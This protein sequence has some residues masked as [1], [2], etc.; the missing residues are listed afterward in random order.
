MI[1]AKQHIYNGSLLLILII[2]SFSCVK[3]TPSSFQKEAYFKVYGQAFEDNAVD[4]ITIDKYHYLLGNI[5]NFSVEDG[6]KNAIILIK[7]NEFGNRIWEKIISRPNNLKAYDLIPLN[8]ESGLAY[9]A[10]YQSD[11]SLYYNDM[12]FQ[13]ITIDGDTTPGIV[14]NKNFNVSGK[15]IGQTDQGSFILLGEHWN[16]GTDSIYKYSMA[17]DHNG[18]V[19][20]YG[21]LKDGRIPQT[22][23]SMIYN[24][25]ENNFIAVGN[26]PGNFGKAGLF[27]IDSLGTFT[28]NLNYAIDGYFTDIVQTGTNYYTC[29]KYTTGKVFASKIRVDIGSFDWISGFGKTNDDIAN[30]IILAPNDLCITG[31][32]FNSNE[33]N[34]AITHVDFDGNISKEYSVGGE[35]NDYGIFTTINEENYTILGTTYREDQSS[36]LVLM[37]TDLSQ[38]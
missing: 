4:M 18:G 9:V 15:C 27:V 7:T 1:K 35:G 21:R 26:I 10:T 3:E 24:P 28:N 36:L 22:V 37:K 16:E 34:M 14:Y 6:S 12:F 31:T 25:S 2:V 32:Q 29:G 17:I 33:C 38:E 19:L 5:T 8:D 20:K 23:T 11:D 13:K 30:S